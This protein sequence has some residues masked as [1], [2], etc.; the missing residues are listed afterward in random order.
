M[1]IAC[2]DTLRDWWI[3]EY[4]NVMNGKINLGKGCIKFKKVK[5]IPFEL[6]R[7]LASK[8]TPKSWIEHYE[9][10]YLK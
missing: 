9:S 6:V 2:D 10:R 8:M 3:S 7:E 4:E 1:G 5:E